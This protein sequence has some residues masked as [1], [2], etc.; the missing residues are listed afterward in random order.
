MNGHPM[1]RIVAR[2]LLLGWFVSGCSPAPVPEQP[3]PDPDPAPCEPGLSRCGETCVALETAPLHCG[4]C[5]RVCDEGHACIGGACLLQCGA[6]QTLCGNACVDTLVDEAHCGSCGETCAE[7]L[8]CSSGQCECPAGLTPCDGGCVDLT[9]AAEHCGACGMSCLGFPGTSSGT[10]TE[11]VCAPVCDEDHADCN[12]EL[13][14][15]C[16]LPISSDREN[17]GGCGIVCGAFCGGGRCLSVSFPSKIFHH[18]CV[19]HEDGR[20]SCWGYNEGG[21]LGDGTTSNVSAP[22]DVVLPDGSPIAELA[23][24]EFHTCARNEEGEVWC[25]GRNEKG[26]LGTGDTTPSPSPVAVYDGMQP[27]TGVIGLALTDASTCALSVGGGVRCWGSGQYGRLGNGGTQDSLVPVTVREGTG[28]LGGVTQLA[29][30]IHHICAR[31]TDGS[32][33]CWGRNNNGQLG[34]GTSGSGTDTAVPTQVPGLTGVDQVVAAGFRTCV[35]IGGSAKCWGQNLF[36]QVG[37]GTTAQKNAPA[38]VIG[39]ANAAHLSIAQ[40]HGCAL[41]ADGRAACWGFN[42]V[43]QLGDGTL[44]TRQTP[45]IVRVAGGMDEW[46]GLR[47]IGAGGAHTCL[48]D[49]AHAV[50]CWGMNNYGQLGEGTTTTST[51]PV[52]VRW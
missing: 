17:C 39:L 1:I 20:A 34:L 45:V 27:L 2:L 35:R 8:V 16:E 11:N 28:E 43:G 14:D 12:G 5:D 4:A 3:I 18:T 7:G 51:V 37:D 15:G 23:S 24:G 22:V 36:G 13:G 42:N 40:N 47:A 6:D 21:Q 10:C 9:S 33:W 26:Q 50:H 38:D 46:T 32:L 52:P 41:L 48:S 31:M 44:A 30:G 19:R 49:S 29:A 25:W